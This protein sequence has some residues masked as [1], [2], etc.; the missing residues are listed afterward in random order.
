MRPLA[1]VLWTC[2]CCFCGPV[3][4]SPCVQC[5]W[6]GVRLLCDVSQ[7]CREF[8][9]GRLCLTIAWRCVSWI[10]AFCAPFRGPGC[11]LPPSRDFHGVFCPFEHF[12]V[13][14]GL[15]PWPLQSSEFGVVLLAARFVYV[16]LVGRRPSF[17]CWG[18]SSVAQCI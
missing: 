13:H 8:S 2:L 15:L 6:G 3:H 12:C 16:R 18:S 5:R 9:S 14:S 4:P 7:V 10:T 17:Y 11:P 1:S